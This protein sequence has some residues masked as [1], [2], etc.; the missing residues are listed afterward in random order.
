M[1]PAELNYTMT[2]K[3]FMVVIYTINKFQH[4]ITSYPTFVHTNHTAII[5]LMNKPITNARVTRWLLLIQE[6]DITIVDKPRKEIVVADFL[7]RLVNNSD[8]SPIE[9]SFPNEHLFVVSTYSPWYADIANYLAASKLPHHL[10]SREKGK[11]IQKSARFCWIEGYLFYT[12]VN[13]EIRKCVRE[14]ETYDIIK[15]CHDETC[16][17][18]FANKRTG[19]KIF[20]MGYYWPTLFQN[21]KKYV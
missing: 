13:Q 17:G 9:D 5:Y 14:D 6:F 21:T 7:S 2:E 20:R 8:N 19:Y 10:S 12:G 4:Y 1:S 16:G 3:E 11:I 18:H 15:S